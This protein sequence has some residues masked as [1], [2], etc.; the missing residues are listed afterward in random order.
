MATGQRELPRGTIPVHAA[1]RPHSTARHGNPATAGPKDAED[2]IAAAL[3]AFERWYEETY[4]ISFWSF[5]R[6]RNAGDP[7]R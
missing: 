1:H 7:S 4:D 2:E 5:V 6:E 3:A